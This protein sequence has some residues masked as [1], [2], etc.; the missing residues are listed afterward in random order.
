[1][2][3]V[4][5]SS[6]H[7][8]AR[9]GKL[10][11]DIEDVLRHLFFAENDLVLIGGS[12]MDGFGSSTSDL[13]I[14]VLSDVPKKLGDFPAHQHHR[15]VSKDGILISVTDYMASTG[16]IVDSQYRTKEQ[17][18][19]LQESVRTAYHQATQ[20]TKRL[21]NTMPEADHKIV[22][23]FYSAVAVKGEA[24]FKALLQRGISRDQFC[25]L[26]FRN[27]AGHYPLFNDVAGAW[28]DGD[29]LEGCERA[30]LFVSKIAQGLTHMFGNANAEIK[31][32][33][34][35][36]DALPDLYRPL[37]TNYRHAIARELGGV[38]EMKRVIVDC[39]NLSDEFF[40]AS[41]QLLNSTPHFMSVEESE[42]VTQ[43]EI[44]SYKSWH[45]DLTR[46]FV[47]RS[48]LFRPNLPPLVDF[49]PRA[50]REEL[51]HFLDRTDLQ[52][53]WSSCSGQL[54][55]VAASKAD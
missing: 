12:L 32:I 8:H 10:A 29:W 9:D 45:R 53:T 22:Y 52:P 37:V 26:L 33:F 28:R 16:T 54:R 49:L 31:W 14:Y 39:L 6:T 43:L 47:I 7:I 41:R 51:S 55:S 30:R 23:R 44:A 2:K 4:H 3:N 27:V 24:G 40:D 18:E 50:E 13:D 46:E 11:I 19:V 5:V 42:R 20:R 1:M 48:R 17:F 36:L 34:R 15:H 38:D 25:Y 35:A 21:L